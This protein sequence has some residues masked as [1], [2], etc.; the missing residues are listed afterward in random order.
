[1]QDSEREIRIGGTVAESD[2]LVGISC[3]EVCVREVE[4]PEVAVIVREKA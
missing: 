1:V 2:G 3:G 4:G